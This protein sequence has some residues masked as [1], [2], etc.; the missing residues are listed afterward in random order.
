MRV[1][2]IERQFVQNEKMW[3][4]N[5]KDGYGEELLVARENVASIIKLNWTKYNLVRIGKTKNRIWIGF[6]YFNNN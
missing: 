2:I 1:L 5:Q 3:C 4:A 6:N